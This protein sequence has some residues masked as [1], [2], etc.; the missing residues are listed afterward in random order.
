MVSSP[1]CS[2]STTRPTS[3]STASR[4]R[5]SAVV[6][7]SRSRTLPSRIDRPARLR[8]TA[9]ATT[10]P[11]KR[12]SSPSRVPVLPPDMEN[13]RLSSTIAQKSAI[14]APAMV[15]CP[16][17]LSACPASFSTGTTRPSEVADKA[18]ASSSGDPVQPTPVKASP[19][20]T[21]RARVTA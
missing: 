14:V 6:S 21:P 16:K 15:A 11:P 12:T 20:A 1:A 9:T 5:I 7:C 4:T 17:G 18:M 10:R 13:S 8:T 2:A 3:S 19:A